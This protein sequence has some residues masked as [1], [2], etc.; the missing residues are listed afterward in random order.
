MPE[1]ASRGGS[2]SGGVSA[3][4]GG[5]CSQGGMS[6]ARGCLLQGGYLFWGGVCSQ[7]VCLLLDGVSTPGCCQLRGGVSVSGGWWG[8]CSGGRACLLPAGCGIPACTETDTPPV[9]RMTNRCKN[10]TLATTVKTSS[11]PLTKTV[12]LRMRVNKALRE[13]PATL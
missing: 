12:T 13:N 2:S 1:C 6:T 8:V 4:G 5:V 3:S 7:G 11:V 9:N 10:I